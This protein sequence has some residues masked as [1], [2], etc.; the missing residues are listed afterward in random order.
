MIRG[1]ICAVLEL[2]LQRVYPEWVGFYPLPKCPLT[3][4]NPSRKHCT[5]KRA[6]QSNNLLCV[7]NSS[8]RVGMEGQSLTS[9]RRLDGDL[10]LFTKFWP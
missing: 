6:T 2:L 7:S 3:R 10:A 8:Q 5:S 4:A 9:R 1:G